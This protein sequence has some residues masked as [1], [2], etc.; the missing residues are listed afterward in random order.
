MSKSILWL[1]NVKWEMAWFPAGC[2]KDM[3]FPARASRLMIIPMSS[4]LKT[5]LPLVLPSLSDIVFSGI[6]HYSPVY[7]P[8]VDLSDDC[9]YL[10]INHKYYMHGSTIKG[11]VFIS[12]S[13]VPSSSSSLLPPAAKSSSCTIQYGIESPERGHVVTAHDGFRGQHWMLIKVRHGGGPVCQGPASIPR[14]SLQSRDGKS[15]ALKFIMCHL[16]MST[17]REEAQSHKE[18]HVNDLGFQRWW[19]H[20]RRNN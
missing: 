17:D 11:C 9:F 19:H 1:L 2:G 12:E 15:T 20:F 4:K 3:R 8:D 18:Q 7:R 10:L 16:R 5:A 6:L 13:S 14:Q